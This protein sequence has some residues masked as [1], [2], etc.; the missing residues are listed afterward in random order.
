MFLIPEY[1]GEGGTNLVADGSPISGK[2]REELLNIFVF[3]APFA[4]S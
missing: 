2:A 1:R 4:N 3:F